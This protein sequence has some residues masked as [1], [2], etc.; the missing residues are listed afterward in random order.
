MHI[1]IAVVVE[2]VV[3]SASTTVVVI[4]S[5]TAVA[6]TT[7]TAGVTVVFVVI[8]S[9]AVAV[10]IVDLC[11][12]W[13]YG[14]CYRGCWWLASA[15]RIMFVVFVSIRAVIPI[16][17]I[18]VVI[19]IGAVSVVSVAWVSIWIPWRGDTMGRVWLIRGFVRLVVAFGL[20]MW[21][22]LGGMKLVFDAS[23]FTVD[24]LR[25][26]GPPAVGALTIRVES[27]R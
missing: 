11:V 1:G 22:V 8:R 23:C 17:S 7:A 5:V 21:T 25:L 10:M 24:A 3:V 19:S 16:I 26:S 6:F 2:S 9:I 12:L 18:R 15:A 27:G 4:A 14:R 13:S 20:Y